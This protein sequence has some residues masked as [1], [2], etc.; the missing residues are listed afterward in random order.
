MFMG[1]HLR[2]IITFPPILF[3]QQPN[4][5]VPSITLYTIPH[6]SQSIKIDVL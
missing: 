6:N 2:L 4:V 1:T 5:V 3:I